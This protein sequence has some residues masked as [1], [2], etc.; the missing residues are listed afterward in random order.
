MNFSKLRTA[1]LTCI[2]GI[3]SVSF[4]RFE[5]EKWNEP[6]VNLP[7]VVSE[8]PIIVKV[9]PEIEG[10]KQVYDSRTAQSG[11]PTGGGKSLL[12]NNWGGG[13]SGSRNNSKGYVCY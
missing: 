5:Y 13:A 11:F 4:F 12:C 2:L 9:C 10:V 3:V 7:Q 8:S 1:I 6:Y